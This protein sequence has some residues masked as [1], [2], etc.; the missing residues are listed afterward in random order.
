MRGRSCD[1]FADRSAARASIFVALLQQLQRFKRYK[2][3]SPKKAANDFGFT[4]R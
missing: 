1:F 3:D 2:S 4:L